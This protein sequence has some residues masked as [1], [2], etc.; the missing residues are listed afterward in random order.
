MATHGAEMECG[1][2]KAKEFKNISLPKITVFKLRE[3]WLYHTIPQHTTQ[4]T[5]PYQNM[6]IVEERQFLYLSLEGC[7]LL[8]QEGQPWDLF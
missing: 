2:K 5:M 1:K 8:S 3:N 4:H 6:W 7:L